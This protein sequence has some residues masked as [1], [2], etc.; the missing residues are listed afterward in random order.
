MIHF[1]HTQIALC[2]SRR[3]GWE[4]SFRKIF[5]R[6]ILR[7]LYWN[8]K[9]I[10]MSIGWWNSVQLGRKF[11][12]VNFLQMSSYKY[13]RCSSKLSSIWE[14]GIE[15]VFKMEY[16]C[17]IRSLLEFMRIVM[18]IQLTQVSQ[19]SIL[20]MKNGGDFSVPIM[21]IGKRIPVSMGH[22]NDVIIPFEGIYIV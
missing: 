21:E 8:E 17:N 15:I 4:S 3:C 18:W 13:V 12:I 5:W 9:G 11:I 22:K 19:W 16:K 6:I 1:I 14:A 20:N 10:S 7:L 2:S